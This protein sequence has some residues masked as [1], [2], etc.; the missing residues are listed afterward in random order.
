MTFKRWTKTRWQ[1]VFPSV[2]VSSSRKR[3]AGLL[4]T[5]IILIILVACTF[6]KD[7]LYSFC[8]PQFSTKDIETSVD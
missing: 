8:F 3:A 6:L 5:Y 2:L 4:S 7:T 1:M